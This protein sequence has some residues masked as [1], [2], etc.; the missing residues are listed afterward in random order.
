MRN[1]RIMPLC[2]SYPVDSSTGEH[3]SHILNIAAMVHFLI[4]TLLENGPLFSLHLFLSSPLI[5]LASFV[6]A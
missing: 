4:K 5:N 2:R 6:V 1:K 3:S